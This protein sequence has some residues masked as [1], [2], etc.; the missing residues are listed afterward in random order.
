MPRDETKLELVAMLDRAPEQEGRSI[1]H[2]WQKA[3]DGDWTQ[4]EPLGE[5]DG[6]SGGYGPAGRRQSNDLAAA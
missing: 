1:L 6:D 2:R 5:P 4:W 3:P